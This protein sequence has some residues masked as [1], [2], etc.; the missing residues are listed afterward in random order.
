VTD[1]PT[2]VDAS[3]Y[4]PAKHVRGREFIVGWIGSPSTAPY[5]VEL[6]GPL[7]Q[8]GREGPVRLV[9]I[10]GKAPV[11]SG[12]EVDE[13]PWSEDTEVALINGFDVGV[14]PLPN[15]DW[16]R[17]KCAFKLIQYMACGI[18]VIGSPVGANS[19][20]VNPD[21]G[22]LANSEHEWLSALRQ[23]RDNCG[24][25]SEMGQAGRERVVR[26]YSLQRNLPVLAEVIYRAANKGV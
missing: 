26:H 7:Q 17:G 15:D 3:R 25:A 2:V 10:G 18:P 12:I 24:L 9:V 16:A 21:C 8:M 13:V 22:F 5:L 19:D 14:M 23:L 11:I 6:V 1:L 4:L 20:V